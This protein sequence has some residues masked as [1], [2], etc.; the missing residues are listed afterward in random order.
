[1]W[2]MSQNAF[3]GRLGPELLRHAAY[4]LLHVAA[5]CLLLLPTP[6]SPPDAVAAE[7]DNNHQLTPA[8]TSKHPT[9]HLCARELSDLLIFEL[10]LLLLCANGVVLL[11]PAHLHE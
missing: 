11:L 7:P 5:C 9:T 1:M 3:Y 10:Q 4:L 8:I 2:E 6:A